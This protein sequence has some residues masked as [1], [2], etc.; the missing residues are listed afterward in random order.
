[1]LLDS[2]HRNVQSERLNAS[3]NAVKY[4]GVEPISDVM[5]VIAAHNTTHKIL[6]NSEPTR[7][8]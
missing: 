4:F 6:E 5:S 8:L 2:V 3:G 1:M 7:Y